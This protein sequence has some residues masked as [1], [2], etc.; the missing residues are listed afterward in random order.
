M[1]V[2]A[3]LRELEA[4]EDSELAAKYPAI[5]SMWRRAWNE[6]IPFLD[7]P[8]EVRKL[9]YTTNAIE[10]LNAKTRRAVRTHSLFPNDE[11]AAKRIY[12]TLNTSSI[13]WKCSLRC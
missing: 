9:I 10:A 11:A 7:Y 5:A 4:F 6:V 2:D 13:D 12:L 3:T 8:P 1:D